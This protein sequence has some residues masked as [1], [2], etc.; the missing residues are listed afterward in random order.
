MIN[1]EKMENY[2]KT[3]K[4]IFVY[5]KDK[6][7]YE[8]LEKLKEFMNKYK[9]TKVKE[10]FEPIKE[11]GV[12]WLIELKCNNCEK[13]YDIEVPKR[14]IHEYLEGKT[15]N[16]YC[17]ECFY[18]MQEIEK[19]KRIE[20]E[21]TEKADRKELKNTYIEHYLNKNYELIKKNIYAI[22]DDIR[23]FLYL[24]SDYEIKKICDDIPY[25]DYLQTPYWKCTS[26]LARRKARYKCQLCGKTN[27]MLNVHH[28]TY[29]NKGKEINNLDDLIVLCKNCHQKF[30]DI[31]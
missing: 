30:H 5:Q 27:T 6:I 4:E 2:L 28:K 13:L 14:F 21:K 29:E 18:K 3:E 17:R 31:I 1:F 8:E 15:K 24:F 9:K 10:C 16:N 7:T 19:Q 23:N 11:N 22:R 20:D 26:E 25:K 12:K